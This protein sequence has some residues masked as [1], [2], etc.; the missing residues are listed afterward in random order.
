MSGPVDPHIPP[1]AAASVEACRACPR[2]A[3]MG[4]ACLPFLTPIHLATSWFRWVVASEGPHTSFAHHRIEGTGGGGPWSARILDAVG[5]GAAAVVDGPRCDA[6][7]EG[8]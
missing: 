7:R 6:A 8:E 5:G 1:S 2:I 3:S 4:P